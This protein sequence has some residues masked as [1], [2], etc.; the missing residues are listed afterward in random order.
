MLQGNNKNVQYVVY[1][2]NL[3]RFGIVIKVNRD[4]NIVFVFDFDVNVSWVFCF[5]WCDV[6]DKFKI[7]DWCSY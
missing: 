2:Y 5:Y 7:I 1:I 3:Y 4:I 6:F